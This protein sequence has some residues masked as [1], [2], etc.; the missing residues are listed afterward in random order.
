[1]SRLNGEAGPLWVSLGG[2]THHRDS[3]WLRMTGMDYDTWYQSVHL[4][5]KYLVTWG[6]RYPIIRHEQV[7]D[8]GNIK[9]WMSAPEGRMLS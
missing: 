4:P 2:G 5:T 1:M 6:C 7:Y 9:Y 3:P 8:I